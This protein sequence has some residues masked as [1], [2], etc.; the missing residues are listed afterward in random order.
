MAFVNPFHN[1]IVFFKRSL[2]FA[3]KFLNPLTGFDNSDD[4]FR[5]GVVQEKV[6]CF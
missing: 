4:M 3:Y 2:C 5:F 6:K 1:G